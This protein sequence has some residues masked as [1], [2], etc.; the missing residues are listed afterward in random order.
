MGRNRS[1]PQA[2][3]LFE[4]SSAVYLSSLFRDSSPFE[5]QILTQR[6][7][8]LEPGPRRTAAEC[9]GNAPVLKCYVL[10]FVFLLRHPESML[11]SIP[12]PR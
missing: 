8:G 6:A 11:N 7:L 1:F 3:S 9:G 4:Q 10:G 5:G 12:A 2:V